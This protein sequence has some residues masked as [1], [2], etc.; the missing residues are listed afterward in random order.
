MDAG[1]KIAL[2]GVIVAGIA[3]LVGLLQ[4]RKAQAWK[5][6][7]FIA[8]EVKEAF[9]NPYVQF[10][11]RLLDWNDSKYDLRQFTGDE[12]LRRVR[13]ADINVAA[14]LVPHS[15]R[16]NGYNRVEVQIRFAFDEL[17][18]RFQRFEHFIESR[19]VREQNFR[20]YL[21]YWLDLLGRPSAS[22]KPVAVL[23][24]IWRYI[25][26]YRYDDVQRFF[27][28]YGYEI[29][30]FPE[31]PKHL[32]GIDPPEMVLEPE[33]GDPG[34]IIRGGLGSSAEGKSAGG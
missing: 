32:S 4:Y 29:S 12:R 30:E 23:H 3:F 6:A 10:A 22:G 24:G 16:P 14:A 15:D 18:G 25:A 7:E 21:R 19:L 33:E 28:R 34:G 26:F 2:L 20:P 1:D 9:S 31:Y 27:R 13:I 5:R 8:N 11:L 17:L